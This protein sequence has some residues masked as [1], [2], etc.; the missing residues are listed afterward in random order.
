MAERQQ[1]KNAKERNEKT[2]KEKQCKNKE[3]AWAI[4]KTSKK[5]QN[6]VG[7]LSAGQVRTPSW[8]VF[9]SVY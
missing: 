2:D 7:R 9:Y 4:K 3:L 8:Y 6:R 1:Q 5:E